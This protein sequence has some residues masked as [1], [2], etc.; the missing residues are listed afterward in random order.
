[1]P[2]L[3]K[4]W[5]V[6]GMEEHSRIIGT[7]DNGDILTSQLID[8]LGNFMSYD[9]ALCLESGN[10]IKTKSGSL[11][12]LGEKFQVIKKEIKNYE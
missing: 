11:Y 4:N 3:I 6:F 1:M 8:S 12:L 10:K 7:T 5:S 2:V 9:V